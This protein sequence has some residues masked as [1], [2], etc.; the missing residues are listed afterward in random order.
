MANAQ[1]QD[2]VETGAVGRLKAVLERLM[3]MGMNMKRFNFAHGNF[4]R[5]HFCCNRQMRSF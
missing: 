3:L 2:G 5:G 4:K 1:N